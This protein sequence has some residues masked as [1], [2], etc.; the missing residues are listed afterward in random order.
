MSE[1]PD[2]VFF[3]NVENIHME[4]MDSHVLWIGIQLADGRAFRSLVEGEEGSWSEWMVE[5]DR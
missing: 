5:E 3:D 4:R 2:D 1:D